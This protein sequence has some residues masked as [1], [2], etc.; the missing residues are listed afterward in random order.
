MRSLRESLKA[1][2]WETGLNGLLKISFFSAG[3]TS[4]AIFAGIPSSAALIAG[5]GISLT[6]S[7]V[8]VAN[9]HRQA[10]INSPYSYLLSMEQQW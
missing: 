3:P 5:V 6:A 8:L 10:K 7:A 2:S 1:Q 9:Q 4:A